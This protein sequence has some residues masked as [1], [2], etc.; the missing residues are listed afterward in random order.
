MEQLIQMGKKLCYEGNLLQEFVKQQQADERADRLAEREL[1]KDTIAA[2]V[3]DR[4][5]ERHRIAAN[6]EFEVA[7]RKLEEGRIEV[8]EAKLRVRIEAT[9]HL[10]HH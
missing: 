3:K 9:C 6:K 7:N 2:Q 1:E 8:E 5:L 10:G 4:E